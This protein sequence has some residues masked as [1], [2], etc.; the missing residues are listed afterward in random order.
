MRADYR[1]ISGLLAIVAGLALIA[2]LVGPPVS[3]RKPIETVVVSPQL[4]VAT[5]VSDE[6]SIDSFG[7]M[8]GCGDDTTIRT[9]TAVLR[10]H[11]SVRILGLANV[12]VADAD[13]AADAGCQATVV[14]GR[15][16]VSPVRYTITKVDRKN[17]WRITVHA[18]A[19]LAQV[20]PALL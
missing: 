18:D 8:P 14:V 9:V 13:P 5:L 15:G 19:A 4:A 20:P 11:T 10:Q 2:Y 17:A 12:A 1:T 3:W 6:M 16:D 7:E